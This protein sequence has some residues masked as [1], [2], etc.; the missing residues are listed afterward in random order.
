MFLELF[1]YEKQIPGYLARHWC[2]CPK[3]C[4]PA[5]YSARICSN[6]YYDPVEP[7]GTVVTTD[8]GFD[9]GWLGLLGLLGLAGLKGRDRDR[10]RVTHVDHTTTTPR[11]SATSTMS[12]NPRY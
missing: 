9:W 4:R 6:Y 5:F 8:D 1:S 11:T 10:D 2:N 3:L 7:V 12:N